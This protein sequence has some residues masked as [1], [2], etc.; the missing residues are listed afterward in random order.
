MRYYLQYM[1]KYFP[2]LKARF[3]MARMN[4][5]E[6]KMELIIKEVENNPSLTDKQKQD[7]LRQ[8]KE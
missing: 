7:I 4:H 5:N 6:E 3:K 2:I 8:I 1:D